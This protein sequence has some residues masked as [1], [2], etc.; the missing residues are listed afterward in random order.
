[1]HATLLVY[2]VVHAPLGDHITRTAEANGMLMVFM[3][4]DVPVQCSV[5][6]HVFTSYRTPLSPS[7]APMH[8]TSENTARRHAPCTLVV[9]GNCL[10]TNGLIPG[11]LVI[12]V[13][14]SCN[15][16]AFRKAILV[17]RHKLPFLFNYLPSHISIHSRG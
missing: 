9:S 1:M 11:A 14:V 5:H 3:A 12:D 17:C 13:Y 7:S 6:Y 15:C 10:L 2:F 8:A 16:V 4:I